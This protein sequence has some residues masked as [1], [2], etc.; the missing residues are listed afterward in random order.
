MP[1]GTLTT[2]IPKDSFFPDARFP[3]HTH[4]PQFIN[5]RV[6]LAQ[7]TPP[8]LLNMKLFATFALFSGSLALS[9]AVFEPTIEGTFCLGSGRGLTD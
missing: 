9:R 3:A 5:S 7:D 2:C 1:T 4:T 6:Y 8:T